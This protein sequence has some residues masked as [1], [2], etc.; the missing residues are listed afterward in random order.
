MRVTPLARQ[1][2]AE[3]LGSAGLVT[4]VIGSGIAP[5]SVPMFVLMQ[6]LGAAVAVGVVH[7]LYPDLTAV[8]GDV[9]VPHEPSAAELALPLAGDGYVELRE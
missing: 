7:I 3:F 2:L 6:L 8:A 5:A 4:I 9:V 1:A